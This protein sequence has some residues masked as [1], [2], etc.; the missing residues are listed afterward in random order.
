MTSL[1]CA[2]DSVSGLEIKQGFSYR[3]RVV[4]SE[5]FAY[6]FSLAVIMGWAASRA[7]DGFP[8]HQIDGTEDG[9]S[10]DLMWFAVGRCTYGGGSAVRVFAFLGVFSVNG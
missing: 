5:L 4:D 6:S 8:M 7:R 2:H 9:Q 10:G 1:V 3:S